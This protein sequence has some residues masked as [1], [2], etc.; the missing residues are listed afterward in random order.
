[1]LAAYLLDRKTNLKLFPHAGAVQ[2]QTVFAECPNLEPTFDNIRLRPTETRLYGDPGETSTQHK[3][4]FRVPLG[5]S[6]RQQTWPFYGNWD[7]MERAKK[8]PWGDLRW[9]YIHLHAAPET[10]EDFQLTERGTAQ[11]VAIK[12]KIK[13]NHSTE[14]G[15][16]CVNA[17]SVSRE[18]KCQS[19]LQVRAFRQIQ[20][21]KSREDRV[22]QWLVDGFPV[23]R[24]DPPHS[25]VAVPRNRNAEA[26][27]WGMEY[28]FRTVCQSANRR[29][30]AGEVNSHEHYV[31][32]KNLVAYFVQRVMQFE[33]DT[34][35]RF[36]VGDGSY[37]RLDVS[38]DGGV[39]TNVVAETSHLVR[40][41]VKRNLP[42]GGA[43]APEDSGMD[44]PEDPAA[45]E[46]GNGEKEDEREEEDCED[47]DDEYVGDCGDDQQ[48]G[49]G[50]DGGK[51]F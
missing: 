11:A 12:R 30:R 43:D 29:G 49:D 46:G 20:S 21:R 17:F 47:A 6:D 32:P 8:A 51:Y 40:E 4:R 7:G 2:L 45:D 50:G 44:V 3:E 16:D 1:M 9:R 13:E 25:D 41:Y 27:M 42:V 22:E 15:S 33:P 38:E 37:T 28:A 23:D 26:D 39:H 14:A 34:F 24:M 48:R 5:E 10:D 31:V 18:P 36:R 19:I 35:G